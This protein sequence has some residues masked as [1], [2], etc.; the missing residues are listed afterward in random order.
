MTTGSTAVPKFE[1]IVYNQFVRKA[2]D[3]MQPNDTGLEDKWAENNYLF[4]EARTREDAKREAD[5]RYPKDRGFVVE[6]GED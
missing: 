2:L 5:R 4:I 6:W 1:I 3:R